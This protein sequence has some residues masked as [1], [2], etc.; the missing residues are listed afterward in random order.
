[1]HSDC[2]GAKMK[3]NRVFWVYF[4]KFHSGVQSRAAKQRKGAANAGH[5]EVFVCFFGVFVRSLKKRK[6]P[7]GGPGPSQ[8]ALPWRKVARL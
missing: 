5:R 7:K 1:M 2:G 6:A 4:S 8:A 3:Y